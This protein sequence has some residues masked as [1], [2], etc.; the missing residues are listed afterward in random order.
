MELQAI[1]EKLQS[2]Q[3]QPP[4]AET[5]S[6][7]WALS[8][9]QMLSGHAAHYVAH[10]STGNSHPVEQSSEHCTA[11]AP[12]TQQSHTERDNS[13][14]KSPQEIAIESLKQRSRG[15]ESANAHVDN[16]V[17]QELYRLEVQ[18]NIINEQSQRQAENILALKRSAQQ[19]SIGLR[20][21]GIQTHPQL[22]VITQFLEHYPSV[23]IP[24]IERDNQG[25]FTLSY[26]TI[27][28]Q[29]AEHDAIATAHA[30]RNRQ[31]PPATTATTS[32]VHKAVL[33]ENLPETLFSHPLPASLN[34]ANQKS[35]AN[36]AYRSSSRTLEL[37]SENSGNQTTSARPKKN[38]LQKSLG[39]TID[40]LL[41]FLGSNKARKKKAIPLTR[42]VTE[43]IDFTAAQTTD[44]AEGF[45]N[46]EL[47]TANSDADDRAINTNEH[48][49]SSQF[50][51][52]DGTIW[53]SGAAIA[54]LVIQ[55]IAI[56]YPIA[57]TLFVLA[58]AS[59]ITFALYK[60]VIARSNNYGLIYR[61]CIA[62]TGLLLTS[63][64][65]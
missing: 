46:H 21:Q 65:N 18:A 30:L 28:F 15:G 3:A 27:D 31:K 61:L 16:L 29:Q 51:W 52:L 1:R 38:R 44:V 59:V 54:R 12:A 20:R 22:T 4:A 9:E 14:N 6:L 56:H 41:Y 24:H 13:D 7:P 2:L 64:F 55:S 37:N 39:N 47:L 50:S 45:V 10:D 26:D 8:D 19:A 5:L 62:M 25:R 63:L 36:S 40:K 58:L 35:D 49:N 32:P 43:G 42:D 48:D 60:V 17:A 57:Q 33:S 23:A 34:R 11:Y 53:F